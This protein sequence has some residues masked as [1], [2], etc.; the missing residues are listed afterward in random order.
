M[1]LAVFQVLIILTVTIMVKPC[2]TRQGQFRV[3]EGVYKPRSSLQDPTKNFHTTT[4]QEKLR[5]F[6]PD[7][8]KKPSRDIVQ[9]LNKVVL[10]K[11]P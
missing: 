7:N 6:V 4:N 5:I 3:A 1:H 8:L 11:K 10:E 9:V 2:P